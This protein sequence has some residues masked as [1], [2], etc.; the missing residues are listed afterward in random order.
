[1]VFV[2]GGAGDSGEPHLIFALIKPQKCVPFE[3][4][5][6]L[7]IALMHFRFVCVCAI[8]ANQIN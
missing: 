6:P 8:F 1:M 5:W 3:N 7:S 4:C 2:V